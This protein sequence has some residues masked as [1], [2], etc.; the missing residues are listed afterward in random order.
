MNCIDQRVTVWIIAIT[1]LMSLLISCDSQERGLV[2]KQRPEVDFF[3][4]EKNFI[5]SPGDTVFISAV[6]RDN[7]AIRKGSV[8]IHENETDTVFLYTFE[9]PPAVFELDTF[10]IVNDP[11]D[12]SY[13]IYIDAVDNADNF[14][15][16]L[17][18]FHQYH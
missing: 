18:F 12:K 2:D 13:V 7:T 5:Y 14:I 3:L 8:H 11:R 1:S 15:Q 9:N 10:W 4:P 16:Q 17:R 6:L